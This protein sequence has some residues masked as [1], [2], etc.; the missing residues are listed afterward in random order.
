[1][2]MIIAVDDV[3]EYWFHDEALRLSQSRFEERNSAVA[4]VWVNETID[5]IWSIFNSFS[6]MVPF[7]DI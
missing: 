1:M 7:L 3:D 5:T 6:L 4:V 2:M